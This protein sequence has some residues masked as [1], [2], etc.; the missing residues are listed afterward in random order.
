MTEL[1]FRVRDVT[2]HKPAHTMAFKAAMGIVE[3]YE[4]V[5]RPLKAKRSSD[6]NKRYWALL[7][8]V[9]ATVWVDGRQFS[10]E[11]WH[12]YFRQQFIGSDSVVMPDGKEVVTPISTTTLSVDEMGHYMRQIEQWCVEQGYP[13]M[14]VA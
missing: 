13:V 2:N 10:D 7:R 1:T 11:V 5:L 4:I 8:E 14:E 3:P 12:T 9:A 6:Q